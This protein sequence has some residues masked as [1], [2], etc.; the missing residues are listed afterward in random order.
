MEISNLSDAEF[1]PLVRRMLTEFSGYFNSIKKTQ[2]EMKDIL[3]EIK[4]NLEGIDNGVDEAKNQINDWKRKEEKDIQSV[5]QEEKRIQKIEDRVSS[6]WDKFKCS[7]I[8]IIG[9]EE[10]REEIGNL[11]EII[12]KENFWSSSQ[13]GG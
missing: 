2:A 9:G 7:N 12:I 13:D 8:H 10:K 1:K 4:N 6:L 11:L 5:Q 3:T